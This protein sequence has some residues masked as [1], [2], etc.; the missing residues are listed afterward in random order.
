MELHEFKRQLTEL[1]TV[2]T[3][4]IAYFSVWRGLMVE[5]E[6]SAHALN[7]Y[8]GLFLPARNA[9]LWM[10]FMQ[11][12]KVFDRDPRTVS[13]RNLLTAAEKDRERLTPYA[14]EEDLQR[15][16]NQIDVSDDLL[17]RLKSLR[18]QRIAHHDAIRKGDQRLLYG[19]MQQLVEEVKAFYNSLTSY[20]DQS[21]TLFDYLVREAERHTS[22]VVN[23]MRE[24]RDRSVRRFKKS[25][26]AI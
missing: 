5:D 19:E 21:T 18:D 17:T 13:L 16:L 20:H 4:G 24:E 14:T 22:Q 8:R 2:I 26:T 10:T 25:D 12:A 3:D 11:F 23:I 15:L 6:V 7:R 1:G 9:L